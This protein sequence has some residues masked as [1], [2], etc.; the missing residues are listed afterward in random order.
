MKRLD[1]F[2][3]GEPDFHYDKLSNQ[4][5]L[6][7]YLDA[8]SNALFITLD[9]IFDEQQSTFIPYKDIQSIETNEA[10]KNKLE[11]DEL[12]LKTF[13]GQHIIISLDG[14]NQTVITG[15]VRQTNDLWVIYTFL[16]HVTK[17]NK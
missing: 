16:R 11:M 14:T 17:Y 6:G 2:H 10:S 12:A 15:S 13:S 4:E 8:R 1:R 5:I 7:Y 9:G 3:I